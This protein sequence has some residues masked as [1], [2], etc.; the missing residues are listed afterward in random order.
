MTRAKTQKLLPGE[1][2]VPVDVLY[3]LLVSHVRYS[4]GRMTYIVGECCKRVRWYWPHLESGHREVLIRDVS[5]EL[6]MS[7][8]TGRKLGMDFDHA[9]W[10]ALKN[11]MLEN[12]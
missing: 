11:W 10:V 5:E 7:E 9:D 1:V 6:A 2:A 12:R 3:S 8:R 4:M